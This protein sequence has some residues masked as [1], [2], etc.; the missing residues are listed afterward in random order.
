MKVVITIPAYNEAKTIGLVL[1]EIKNVMNKENYNYELLVVD[2]GSIDKTA[3]IAKIYSAKVVSHPLNRGLA[4]AFR[5]EI[6]ECLN[7]HADIIVHTDADGQYNAKDIPRL[8]KQVEKGNDLVLGDRFQ[9]GIE[10]MPWL[11][12]VGNKAF[13]HT[14]SKILNHKINDCQTGFR[15]FNKIVARLAIIS[16]HTYTQEQIIRAIKANLKVKSIPTYF[17]SRK[18]KSKLIK[19]P[20]EY[21]IKAWLNLFRIYRDYE[22]LKFFGKIGCFLLFI[23]LILGL[24]FL[25]LHFTTGIIGHLGL[26]FLML[27]LLFTGFQIVIFGFL[28][29]M[30]K[31]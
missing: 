11:K 28:A 2:D 7:M 16:N 17:S 18:G 20:F 27:I 14:I 6:K 9:G 29:D 12:E 23:A 10:N 4:E 22:P 25:Y 31:K 13:S 24:Y 30:H 8:I 26:L 15:A 1:Q 19:N 21:A 3:Q 5:T